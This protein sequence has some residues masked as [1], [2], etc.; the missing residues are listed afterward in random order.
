MS[1]E[2][3]QLISDEMRRCYSF[4]T[5]AKEQEEFIFE[6]KKGNVLFLVLKII[7][8][9]SMKSLHIQNQKTLFGRYM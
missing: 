2:K 9:D 5:I 7:R 4:D 1:K 3:L 8:N 6:C